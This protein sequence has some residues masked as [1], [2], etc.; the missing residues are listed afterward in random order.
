MNTRNR[1]SSMFSS[2]QFAVFLLALLG[3]IWAQTQKTGGTAPKTVTGESRPSPEI[4]R[5]S[6]A[7]AGRW[8]VSETFQVGAS[9][10]KTRQGTASF[11]LGPG[12]SL[13][14]DYQSNGSAGE[15]HFSGSVVGSVSSH[16][17]AAHLRQQR[18]LPTTGNRQVGVQ[19]A[20]DLVG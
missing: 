19:G 9:P 15:L 14:E 12:A 4:E 13:V 17:S 1:Q 5:L 11:R 8:R 20:G 7:L 2:Y 10:G 16:L 18:R 6:D 3:V